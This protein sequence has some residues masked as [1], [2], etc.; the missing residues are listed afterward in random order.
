ML[1]INAIVRVRIGLELIVKLPTVPYHVRTEVFALLLTLAT[2]PPASTD[3][4]ANYPFAIRRA[5]MEET[6]M[7]ILTIAAVSSVLEQVGLER[8][9]Q[10]LFVF[11]VSMVELVKH[12][13]VV[14]VREPI[15]RELIAVCLIAQAFLAEDVKMLAC[16]LD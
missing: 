5:S 9:A 15:I 14:I 12:R 2:A 8:T 3:L 13:L 16:V 10:L 11:L 1:P 4:N 7:S 6:V